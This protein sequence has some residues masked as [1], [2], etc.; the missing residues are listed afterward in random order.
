MTSWGPFEMYFPIAISLS[1]FNDLLQWSEKS[2]LSLHWWELSAFGM[3]L[4]Y[5]KLFLFQSASS[6]LQF[7]AAQKASFS[8]LRNIC[9]HHALSFTFSTV[10]KEG[11]LHAALS[12]WFPLRSAVSFYSLSLLLLPHPLRYSAKSQDLVKSTGGIYL[13]FLIYTPFV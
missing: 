1:N 11:N 13:F 7:T 10:N 12:F 9:H 6:L 3:H 8:P 2:V 5:T 4:T